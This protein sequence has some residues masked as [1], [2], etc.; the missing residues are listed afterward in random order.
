MALHIA[1]SEHQKLRAC[2]PYK[3]ARKALTLAATRAEVS[4]GASCSCAAKWA[5][6]VSSRYC[7]TAR[8][9][10][11]TVTRFQARGAVRPLL[12]RVVRRPQRAMHREHLG[13][14]RSGFKDF[15]IYDL[16]HTFASR[17]IDE[18][19][20]R[21][22]KSARYSGTRNRRRRSGTRTSR[23]TPKSARSRGRLRLAP[24]RSG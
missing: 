23:S 21:R 6:H 4:A 11:R 18:G 9:R 8:I 2:E 14:A 3:E 24:S 1:Q 7:S 5:R 12:F 16:R 19:V 15:R 17:L 22:R 13:P 10:I 20:R